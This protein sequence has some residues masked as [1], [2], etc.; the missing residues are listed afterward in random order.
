MVSTYGNC[1][2]GFGQPI[3]VGLGSEHVGEDYRALDA[4]GDARVPRTGVRAAD[5]ESK[6]GTALLGR[7]GDTADRVH[8]VLDSSNVRLYQ[9][10]DLDRKSTRLN[11]SHLG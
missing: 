1:W 10:A 8:R 5:L 9:R 2:M 6:A 11:S 7:V 4:S 3:W